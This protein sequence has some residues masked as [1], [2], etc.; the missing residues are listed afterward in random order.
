MDEAADPYGRRQLV[1][2]VEHHR[3]GA[4]AGSR[5]RVARPRAA[6]DQQQ[7]RP[8]EDRPSQLPPRRRAQAQRADDE[9]DAREYS[10]ETRADEGRREQLVRMP[11]GPR[12][13]RRDDRGQQQ[14]LAD[15]DDAG[16][17]RKQA[18]Q[19][20]RA[21]PQHDEREGHAAD[22]DRLPRKIEPAQQ[23]VSERGHDDARSTAPRERMPAYR[24]PRRSKTR[25]PCRTPSRG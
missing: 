16:T 18:P 25:T 8:D 3:R 22:R 2:H 23:D 6:H 4:I 15:G 24:R 14:A 17:Q 19:A 20:W 5:R 21:R 12:A 7:R 9:P 13:Q 10:Y 11:V 1:E